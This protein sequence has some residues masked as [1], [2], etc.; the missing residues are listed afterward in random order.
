[1]GGIWN[2]GVGEMR[3]AYRILFKNLKGDDHM[4]DVAV[5]RMVILKCIL[6]EKVVCVCWIYLVQD[7]I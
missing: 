2:L 6:K 4:E 1:V 7:R 5:V 3:N